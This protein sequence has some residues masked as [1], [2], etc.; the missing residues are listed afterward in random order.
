MSFYRL[1]PLALLLIVIAPRGGSGDT[2][3]AAV[4]ELFT[5]QGCSSCPPADRLLSK[6]SRDPKYQGRVIPLSFH[7]DYW[8]QIGWT[9]PFSSARWSERQKAYAGRV[10]HVN[11]IYTPQVVVNGRAE[12][13][14][15]SEAKV[16]Q[17]IGDALNAEPAA[18]VS[19]AVEPPTADGRLKVKV[20]ARLARAAG[21]GDLDLWVA[22][23]ESGLATEVKAGENASRLLRNDHVVRR[24]EK[25]LSLPGTVGAEKSG[26]IQLGIDKRW[27][28]ESLGVAAF[29]QDPA[30]LAIHG[31]AARP[32]TK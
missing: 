17:R 29:L 24:L 2:P 4:V 6:L 32:V 20:G 9:D 3:G 12:C 10:F 22:I 5:S 28:T 27:R 31:S 14:G 30:T 23:Y 18:R 26:E 13:V 21:S 7:V 25:A 16:L 19:L 8:N 15:N 11:R 1:L